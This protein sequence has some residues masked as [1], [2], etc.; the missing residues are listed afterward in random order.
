MLSS[1]PNSNKIPSL[2]ST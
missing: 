1:S 2:V